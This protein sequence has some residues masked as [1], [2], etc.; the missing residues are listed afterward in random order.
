MGGMIFNA[1]WQ[2]IAIL[3][4]ALIIA[5]SIHELCHGLAAYKFGD[6]TAKRDGRLSLNPIR[7]LDPVGLIFI[8][9][10]GFG[11]AKPV[12]VNPFNLRNPR[13]DMAFIAVAGPV[14]NFVLAFLAMFLLH[15]SYRLGIYQIHVFSAILVFSQINIMLGLFNML[16]IPPLDGSKVIAGLLPESVYRSLP[17]VGNYG[18]IILLIFMITGMTGRILFPLISAFFN[19]FW[20][21]AGWL[22]WLGA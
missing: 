18:M 7:H 10:V 15:L 16:P 13:V 9:V 20:R 2:E 8:L 21:G 17:P 1:T 3:L 12:M 6:S 14:S 5:L 11:W 4:P 19:A 22:A